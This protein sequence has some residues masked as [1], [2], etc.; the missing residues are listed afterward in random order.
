MTRKES[1][2]HPCG[3]RKDNRERRGDG[4]DG[5]G[6]MGCAGREWEKEGAMWR[7]LKKQSF[8]YEDVNGSGMFILP[9]VTVK[10]KRTGKHW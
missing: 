6:R 1:H 8:S 7:G 10:V 3:R 5:E 2:E 4:A 9:S